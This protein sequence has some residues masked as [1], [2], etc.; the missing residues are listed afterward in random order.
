MI[1]ICHVCMYTQV[2]A[3][4]GS[5]GSDSGQPYAAPTWLLAALMKRS[6]RIAPTARPRCIYVLHNVNLFTPR[7]HHDTARA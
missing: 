1:C 5:G 3:R 7:P 6:Q 4:S 2:T